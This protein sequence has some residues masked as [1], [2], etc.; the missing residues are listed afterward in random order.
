MVPYEVELAYPE[1]Y[2]LPDLLNDLAEEHPGVRFRLASPLA[3]GAELV[4]VAARRLEQAWTTPAAGEAGPRSD[5][6]R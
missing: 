1:V 6:D 2:D 3:M 5:S 4:D